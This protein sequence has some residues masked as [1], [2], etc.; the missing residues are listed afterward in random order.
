MTAL[1]EFISGMLD[2][3][4][5]VCMATAIGGLVFSLAVLRVTTADSLPE[6]KATLRSL[7]VIA[8]GAFSLSGLRLVCLFLTPLAL[9][10]IMGQG[11]FSLFFTTRVFQSGMI[12]AGLACV[13]GCVVLWIRHDVASKGRWAMGLLTMTGLLIN[14]GWLSHAASRVEGGELLMVVTVLHVIGA[15]VWAGGIIHLLLFWQWT[16]R[17]QGEAWP[18]VVSRFSPL[19]MIAVLLIA[20]PGGFLAWEYVG[21]FAG[22][23]GSGYGN[24]VTVKV[25]FFLIV[26]FLAGLNF[27]AARHWVLTGDRRRV[28]ARVPA[29]VEVEL[30][31]AIA[32][33]FTASALTSFPPSIDVPKD[34]AT[35]AEMWR[36][37]NPKIP[38]LN[39]PERVNI[40]APELTNLRTG[41]IGQKENMSWDRFNHN[42]SG[43]IVLVITVVALLDRVGWVRWARHWPLMFV[44]FSVL[45]MV[46]AN[47]DH[48]PL[49]SI[50][51]FDSFRDAEV[52]QH[53]LAGVVVFGLGLFEWRARRELNHPRL[54]RF[55]F[56]V[57]C[58]VGGIILLTH[59]HQI[60]ELKREFLVQS[61]H[62]TMGLLGVLIGCARWLELR[63]SPP[64]DR[65]AGILSICG[66]FLVGCI[67]LFYVNPDF[68][69]L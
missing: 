7:L 44:G 53:W 24:M 57:L 41:Q 21:S 27:L 18:V 10:D 4:A 37:F 29:F 26:L 22:L 65:L 43:V 6:Q 15:T 62:V 42:I 58:M 63:L 55:V 50:S 31:L 59:S 48:W 19:G 49:G 54:L 38:H 68:L 46:F 14:E 25:G 11:A 32:L 30:V 3:L 28:M 23:I 9:V 40:P 64:H 52:V 60:N 12:S 5:L 39:G 13:L 16:R 1:L 8:L 17:G 69:N 33:L 67:L 20:L 61:T 47:P 34:M 51:F 2:G 36:M 45:I 35:P 56:P 66:I